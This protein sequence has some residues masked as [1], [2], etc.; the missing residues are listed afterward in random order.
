MGNRGA[1]SRLRAPDF[2]DDERLARLL[3]Q[4]R[5]TQKPG[6]VADSLEQRPHHT[7]VVALDEIPQEIARGAHALVADR[8]GDRQPD[9]TRHRQPAKWQ[10]QTSTLA[11]DSDP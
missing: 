2:Q 7:N 11:A 8:A 1:V 9:S 5:S 10:E 3:S 4:L 6:G